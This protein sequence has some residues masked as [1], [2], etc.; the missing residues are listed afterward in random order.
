M[1]CC[2][3]TVKR[4]G[5]LGVSVTSVK[6]LTVKMETVSQIAKDRQNLTCFVW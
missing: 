4:R 3:M 2:G 1:V 6:V 5:L